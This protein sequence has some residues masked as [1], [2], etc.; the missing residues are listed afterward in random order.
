M[1]DVILTKHSI[2]AEEQHGFRSKRSCYTYLI[3]FVQELVS[4]EAGGGQVDS[5]VLDFS[6]AYDKVSHARL[7][8][9]LN[10]YGIRSK[11]HAWVGVFLNNRQE[12]VVLDGVSV[13]S[14]KAFLVFPNVLFSVLHCFS[15]L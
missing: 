13:T 11:S 1:S 5:L 2:L 8:N 9:K 14:V 6:K 15:S 4:E 12:Y 3:T 7:M 10:F